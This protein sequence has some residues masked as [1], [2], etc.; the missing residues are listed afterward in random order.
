M[1]TRSNALMINQIA[2]EEIKEDKKDKDKEIEESNFHAVKTLLEMPNPLAKSTEK[3]KSG[4][5]K[6][7]NTVK[8]KMMSHLHLNNKEFI[9]N[10]VN[11]KA[12]ALHF[13][14]NERKMKCQCLRSLSFWSGGLEE[15]EH[16]V[17]NA[18][19]NLIDNAQHY[20]YI[21]NQFFLSRSF[22]DEEYEEKKV[23][24]SNLIINE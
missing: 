21:E 20:I 19:M 10:Y 7:K 16:S 8:K 23:K 18:Y 1:D 9:D 3:K 4:F 17:L 5:S 13:Q 22:T 24:P 2:L 12:F 6:L 14:K 11:L 15:T